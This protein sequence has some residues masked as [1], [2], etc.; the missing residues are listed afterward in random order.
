[1]GTDPDMKLFSVTDWGFN[2]LQTAHGT[3]RLREAGAPIAEIR[4]EIIYWGCVT[5]DGVSIY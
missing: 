2:E 1:M 5:I 3:Q 4:N